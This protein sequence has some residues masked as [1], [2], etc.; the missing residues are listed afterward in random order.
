[1]VVGLWGLGFR[2]GSLGGLGFRI[3]GL[4]GLGFRIVGVGSLE[5]KN[6]SGKPG[7]TPHSN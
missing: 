4:G 7:M 6:M 2:I 3:G 1:M 5:R